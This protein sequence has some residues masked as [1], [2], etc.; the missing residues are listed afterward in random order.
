MDQH[1]AGGAAGGSFGRLLA[2]G[3][4]FTR[5]HGLWG[6][7]LTLGTTAR[8]R[9]RGNEGDEP[10]ASV[11]CSTPRLILPREWH[12]PPSPVRSV[13]PRDI[14]NAR[15]C[16]CVTEKT[17]RLASACAAACKGVGSGGSISIPRGCRP[18]TLA[19]ST[20]SKKVENHAHSVALFAIYYNFVHIHKTLRTRQRWPL[21]SRRGFGRL[22]I[23]WTYWKLGKW[24]LK[25]RQHDVAH[26]SVWQGRMP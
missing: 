9:R 23:S 14:E 15:F 21:A 11:S 16:G 22:V 10:N 7:G 4:G 12:Q 25:G 18:T 17:T 13:H 1:G 20:A 19:A 24:P 5:F 26:G 6:T 3:A 2:T 8:P